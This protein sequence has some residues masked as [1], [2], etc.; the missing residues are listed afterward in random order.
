MLELWEREGAS[1]GAADT[2]TIDQA[3]DLLLDESTVA[4]L[5]ELDGELVGMGL[6]SARSTLG[7]IHRVSVPVDDPGAAGLIEQLLG[8]LEGSLA[9]L[10][11]R[12]IGM[13]IEEGH[14][15]A[16]ALAERE[17]TATPGARYLERPLAADYAVPTDLGSVRGVV[18]DPYLWEE[19]TGVDEAKE[20]IER[21]VILPLAAA[22]A[23][24]PPRRPSHRRRSSSSARRAPGRR[25]SRRA[26]RRGCGWPFVEIQP[27]EIGG[28][29]AETPGAS[30]WPRSSTGS[31]GLPA[32][33]V[34]VD[35]VED[36]A[37]IRHESRKRQSERHERVPEAD[38]TAARGASSS[39][40]LR[41]ELGQPP[42]PG[43]FLRPGRFDYVLPGWPAGRRR[44][45]EAIWSRYVD[46]ITDEHGRRRRARRARATCSRR[47]TSSSR[48]ARRRSSRSSASTSSSSST[49]ARSTD[50][51]LDAIRQTRSTLT[52]QMVRDFDA[53]TKSF[54][55]Y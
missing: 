17:Y 21:R 54:S 22:G 25:R 18:I 28:E 2:M 34:F 44:S 27:A 12:R 3:V 39:A 48:P 24:R 45:R 29:G 31:L 49:A 46:E 11:A 7:R 36:L 26:S 32:A 30:C 15:V 8:R 1:R 40:R 37:S 38:P 5:A 50:D 52:S 20:I 53:D 35:E 42:R 47:P 9:A 4:L 19:L 10:G 13:L 6:A 55:R 43:A 14:P 23:G 41:D 51:F 33:V 16:L